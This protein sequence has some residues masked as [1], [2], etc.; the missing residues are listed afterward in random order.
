MDP[1][2]C[3]HSPH[4]SLLHHRN[5][6]HSLNPNC[7][8]APNNNN[9]ITIINNN[10]NNNIINNSILP[11]NTL[12]ST[13]HSLSGQGQGQQEP[14]NLVTVKSRDLS[15]SNGDHGFTQYSP[16][17]GKPLKDSR[18]SSSPREFSPDNKMKSLSAVSASHLGQMSHQLHPMSSHLQLA[19]ANIP[20]SQVSLLVSPQTTS[21]IAGSKTSR[22][23]SSDLLIRPRPI[24]ELSA[25]TVFKTEP[26]FSPDVSKQ[27]TSAL[28]IDT[29]MH[30]MEAHTPRKTLKTSSGHISHS[31]SSISQPHTVHTHTPWTPP[32]HPLPAPTLSTRTPT[33]KH[34]QQHR[35]P[36]TQPLVIQ[37]QEQHEQIMS[38]SK[39]MSFPP[40]TSIKSEKDR[41]N[42]SWRP[43]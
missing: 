41:N 4:S 1:K 35:V 10:I 37:T 14:V 7:C 8:H 19:P 22:S 16:E 12:P 32:S 9:N 13:P 23:P 21:S 33:S 38:K 5:H 27:K 24:A 3:L 40:T 17:T 11:T 30:S 15:S 43:W 20:S 26:T 36:L 42:A 2:T 29:N 34:S 28:Y 25:Q 39:P 18:S 6:F 31:L